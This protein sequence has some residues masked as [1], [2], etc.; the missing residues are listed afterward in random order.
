MPQGSRQRSGVE[1]EGSD[2][3]VLI[4]TRHYAPEPTGSGPVMTSTATWLASQGWDVRVLTVQPSYPAMMSF[5]GTPLGEAIEDGVK[6]HRLAA[7]PAASGALLGRVW[8]ELKFL[9][10]IFIMRCSGRLGAHNCVVSLCPS[11][12][13]VI[14]G[15]L[16]VGRNGRHVAIVHDIPSGIGQTLGWRRNGPV[17]RVVRW[18]EAQALN[19]TT[20]VVT[21]STHMEKAL[22]ALGVRRPIYVQ[23]PH[24][25]VAALPVQPSSPNALRWMYSGNLGRK[26]GLGQLLDL[27]EWLLEHQPNVTLVIQGE[28]SQ[29]AWLE[30]SAGRRHL[31]NVQFSS[32]APPQELARSLGEAAVHIV[33]QIPGS[34]GFVVPSKI[35]TLMALGRPFVAVAEP[36]SLLDELARET[37]AFVTAPPNDL[38]ALAEA[39][40]RLS[41]DVGQRD[42]MAFKGRTFVEAV[43]DT[44]VVMARFTDLLHPKA[45]DP[46]SPLPIAT[47]AA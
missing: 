34:N 29:R 28:G 5:S 31:T 2:P 30:H 46:T 37:Q 22:R 13:A 38:Q 4:I 23:P 18:V 11:I 44:S 17:L 47:V 15:S 33:P 1:F 24:L 36:G 40:L 20:Q 9:L 6:I 27:A 14:A 7:A 39:C 45:A 43:A 32:L 42:I 41:G 25:D 26:Q 35:Y 21:L 12:L 8:P 3:A 10:N 19:S 16:A